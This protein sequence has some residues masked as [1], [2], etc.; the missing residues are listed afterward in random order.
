MYEGM[1]AKYK[2]Y[3]LHSKHKANPDRLSNLHAKMKIGIVDKDCITQPI[4]I[5][6]ESGERAREDYVTS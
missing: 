4:M 2:M 1:K 5:I 3:L 6:M